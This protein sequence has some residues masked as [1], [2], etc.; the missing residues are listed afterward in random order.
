MNWWQNFTLSIQFLVQEL[1]SFN[2]KLQL[3]VWTRSQCHMR[4]YSLYRFLSCYISSQRCLDC[5]NPIRGSEVMNFY[6]MTFQLAVFT[7][8]Q[9]QTGHILNSACQFL[10]DL[11][12]DIWIEKIQCL[13]QELW[14]FQNLNINFRFRPE[15]KVKKGQILCSAWLVYEDLLDDGWIVNI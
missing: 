9:G 13:F 6:N 2:I 14:I 5:K 1:Y 12:D 4:S 3:P 10:Y 11:S 8:S 7:G 15:A